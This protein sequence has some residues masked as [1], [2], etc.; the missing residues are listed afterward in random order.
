MTNGRAIFQRDLDILE[1]SARRNLLKFSKK[2]PAP[3]VE[4]LHTLVWAVK[5][6]NC[7]CIENHLEVTADA[8]LN[9]DPGVHSHCPSGNQH[10]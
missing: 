4:Q 1:D 7:S 2:K 10:T 5:R 9:M 6:L 3:Q 8:R